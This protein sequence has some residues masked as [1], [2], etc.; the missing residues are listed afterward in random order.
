VGDAWR[1]K[2]AQGDVIVV[3][4]ADDNVLGF[5]HLAEADRFLAEFQERLRKF[6]LDLHPDRTRRIEFGR[7]AEVNR[8][9]RGEGKPEA[10]DFLGLTHISGKDRNGSY[11]VERKTVSKRL[12]AKLLEAKQ[13]LRK[14]MPE[15]EAQKGR[16][17]RSIV[18]GYFNY[19]Q[20][21]VTSTACP[22]SA[23]S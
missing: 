20:N 8:T 16:W 14:R 9:K 7:F 15:P 18:H 22:H 19:T 23:T 4:Y 12:R 5:Q 10:V 3:R 6:G 21:R 2:C 17:L 1:R 13:Q 11:A